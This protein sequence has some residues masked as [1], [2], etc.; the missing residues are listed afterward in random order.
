MA[1]PEEVYVPDEARSGAVGHT[2]ALAFFWRIRLLEILAAGIADLTDPELPQPRRVQQGRRAAKA[3]SALLRLAPPGLGR[4]ARAARMVL[5]SVR[6]SLGPSRDLDALAES[7]ERIAPKGGGLNGKAS[8][9]VETWRERRLAANHE[10]VQSIGSAVEVL[11]RIRTHISGWKP[12]SA[13]DG[14]ILAA[15]AQ[16]YRRARRRMP[17]DL[18]DPDLTEFHE[19]RKSVNDI[20]HQLAFLAAWL[21]EPASHRLDRRSNRLR[22]LQVA[23]G[24][25]RDLSL[26]HTELAGN[27]EGEALH[28]LLK[29]I[30]RKLEERLK[31]CR[32][33]A[34]RLFE[35]RP[36][37]LRDTLLSFRRRPS[38]LARSTRGESARPRHSL[39]STAQ[40]QPRRSDRR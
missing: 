26:L 2:P 22:R 30:D 21:G 12:R 31:T 29:R 4:K 17:S 38:R 32:K 28:R 20:R 18:A 24:E 25:H 16:G 39:R 23:I 27:G 34:G 40:P 6:R 14:A 36:R 9:F 33:L 35:E 15:V 11:Q 37:D 19:W 10:A 13:A 3:T 8:R 5:A 7:F 1:N